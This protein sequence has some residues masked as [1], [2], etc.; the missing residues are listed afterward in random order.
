M[1][2]FAVCYSRAE[3]FKL[4]L[5]SVAHR[6]NI[7][8]L[9][10]TISCLMISTP[11]SISLKPSRTLMMI[12]LFAHAASGILLTIL[13]LPIWLKSAGVVL[14]LVAA[15]QYVRHY[16]LLNTKNAVRELRML[17]N[18]RLD[19]FRTDW[20]SAQLLGEQ[21]IHP[22]LTIIRCRVESRGWPITIVILPDMLDAESFRTLRVRLKWRT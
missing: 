16:A 4:E 18:A 1:L 3:R 12:L 5:P 10:E 6:P 7:N 22:Y 17:P 2:S 13:P 19:I 9:R 14:V 21:F 8:K 15:W 11:L 20:Q